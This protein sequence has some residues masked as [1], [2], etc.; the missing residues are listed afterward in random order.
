MAPS[1]LPMKIQSLTVIRPQSFFVQQN[2]LQHYFKL[3][4]IFVAISEIKTADTMYQPFILL[5]F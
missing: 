3:V 4:N 5:I 2:V 1:V